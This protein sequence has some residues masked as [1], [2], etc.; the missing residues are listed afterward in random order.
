MRARG[1][2][3]AGARD[4]RLRLS[5]RRAGAGDAAGG[6]GSG[7]GRIAGGDTQV[8]GVA[9][10]SFLVRAAGADGGQAP[11]YGMSVIEPCLDWSATAEIIGKLA[12]AVQQRQTSPR[13]HAAAAKRGRH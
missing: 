10:H 7:G 11:I 12:A 6:G 9:L 1:G 4:G 13:R 5:Q 8:F 2:G 3:A